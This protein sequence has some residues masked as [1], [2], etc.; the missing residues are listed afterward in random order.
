[1]SAVPAVFVG[2]NSDLIAKVAEVGYLRKED[3]ILDPTYGKG[4]FWKRWKPG[5]RGQLVGLDLATTG[6]D[7]RNIHYQDQTFEVVVFDPP[8]KL[9]GKPTPAEDR[10]YGTHERTDPSVRMALACAGIAECLRVTMVGGLLLV[11]CQDQV[12]YGRV[13]WQTMAFTQAA[14]DE[15]AVL[16]DMVHLLPKN[17]V[18]RPQPAGRRQVHFRRIYSTLLILRKKVK[19]EDPFA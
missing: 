9:N 8:Y 16:E 11:K 4:N 14:V 15:G 6:D 12:C 10:R 13:W 19:H 5:P 18:G 17:G 7:F 2:D 3:R 1:M